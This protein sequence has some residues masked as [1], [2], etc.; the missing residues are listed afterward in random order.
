MS[1]PGASGSQ[2]VAKL[3]WPALRASS[4]PAA[5]PGPKR[6]SE[7]CDK[8]MSTASLFKAKPFYKLFLGDNAPKSYDLK[9]SGNS[10]IFPRF[11]NLQF[12]SHGSTALT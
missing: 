2:L 3:A 11:V 8:Q 7:E 12:V 10:L 5:L 4:P 1:L 9:N 6:T